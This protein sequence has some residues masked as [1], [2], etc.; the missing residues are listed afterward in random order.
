MARRNA[1]AQEMGATL[2]RRKRRLRLAAMSVAAMSLAAAGALVPASPASA[3]PHDC[4]LSV[5]ISKDP[6]SMYAR[7]DVNCRNKEHFA[8]RISIY[9]DDWHGNSSVASR[10]K[11]F[12][13]SG[14]TYLS[15]SEPCSDVD[16]KKKYHA[17]AKLYDTRFGPAVEVKDV[18]STTVSGH[19]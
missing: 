18:K 1:G 3:R 6:G 10:Y 16:P 4:S 12:H 5:K 2:A 11:G 14:Y 9:R 13:A 19:C 8:I 15:T 7:A 17:I